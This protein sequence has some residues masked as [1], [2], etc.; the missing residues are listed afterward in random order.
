[1]RVSKEGAE[2]NLEEVKVTLNAL[3]STQTI[4]TYRGS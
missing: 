1:M 2:N 3:D 4:N